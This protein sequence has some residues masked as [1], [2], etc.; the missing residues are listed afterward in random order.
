MSIYHTK[1]SQNLLS[2]SSKKNFRQSEQRQLKKKV[3]SQSQLDKVRKKN[4]IKIAIT[5]SKAYWVHDNIFYESEL[6]DGH[7]DNEKTKPIDAHKLSKKE[8]NDLLVILDGI[9]QK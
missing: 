7:I 5:D 8:V 9:N 2:N 6:I 4:T 1:F 3:K